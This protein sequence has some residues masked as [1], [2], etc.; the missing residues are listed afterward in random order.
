VRV[1]LAGTAPEAAVAQFGQLPGAAR[2][3]LLPGDDG[4]QGRV[5]VRV[6][7]QRDEAGAIGAAGAA[8]TV[9]VAQAAQAG[10]WQVQA[11]STEEG[12]LEDVFRSITLP[13]TV[14]R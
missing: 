6:Y 14:A 11:L 2:A 8:L 5:T 4:T 13:D 9:A 10:G 1:T 3:E 12:R 7:P